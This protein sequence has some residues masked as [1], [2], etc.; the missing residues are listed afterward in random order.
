MSTALTR[1]RVESAL[2]LP[3]QRTERHRRDWSWAK[4]QEGWRHG[5]VGAPLLGVGFAIWA[6]G[7]VYG[8]AY[9]IAYWLIF[10]AL[11]TL[12]LRCLMGKA[13]LRWRGEYTPGLLMGLI[14][15]VQYISGLTAVKASTVTA[16]LHLG[17]GAALFLVLSQCYDGARDEGWISNSFAAVTLALALLAILQ[18]LTAANGIYWHFSYQY[19]SPAGSFVNRNHFAGCMEML[20]PVA[21]V[22][23]YRRRHLYWLYWIPWI[24]PPAVGVAAVLLTGSRG[25]FGA[26]ATEAGVGAVLAVLWQLNRRSSKE[27]RENALPLPVSGWLPL[28]DSERRSLHDRRRGERTRARRRRLG[29]ALALAIG[30][31][32]VMVESVGTGRLVARLQQVDKNAPSVSDRADLNRSSWRMFEE[33]PVLGWGLG[34]WADVYPAYARFN[35]GSIYAF[36]HNDYLQILAETGTAGALCILLFWGMWSWGL[37]RDWP[38]LRSGGRRGGALRIAAAIACAGMLV[39]SLVDFNLHIPA[40]LLLFF[41][42]VAVAMPPIGERLSN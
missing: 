28:P 41:G 40:N 26:L 36:A 42:L 38:A 29:F 19:A 18:I 16:G 37:G 31:T 2:R 35:D 8:W 15:A 6:F 22:A 13:R 24:A 11:A 32:L 9:G 21:C 4:G 39:H 27:R 1:A 25:G 23:A 33:K 7:G 34:T 17:A 30:M 10:G 20:L 5:M 14:V 12:C 3:Q